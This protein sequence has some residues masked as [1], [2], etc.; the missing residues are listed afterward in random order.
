M[1]RTLV[2]GL[3]GSSWNVL[4]PLLEA[5]RMPN[6]QALRERG[7][8][9][10]LESSLPFYTGPA[11]ASYATGASPAAHGIWDFMMVREG[12]AMTVAHESDLRR[13]TYYELLADQGRR[14]V[15]INLVLDQEE[16]EGVTIVNSWLTEDGERRLFPASAR[17]RYRRELDAYVSYPTTFDEPL[18]VHLADLQHLE[19]THMALARR[20]FE[21]EEWDHFYILF[22]SPDWLGHHGTGAFAQGDPAAIEAFGRL[23]AQLDSYIGW[24][25][26]RAPARRSSCSPTTGSARRRT[27]CASTRSCA[28]SGT[29]S[30]AASVPPRRP[31]P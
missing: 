18:D 30:C 31:R 14:S 24:F 9:G 21:D 15:L 10:P 1:S 25:V 6:L 19:E 8:S 11:W 16:H 5:G 20:L 2:I 13:R 4:D 17:E 29:S 26:E 23:Y 27:S 3:D 7:A 12:D 28:G 22:S